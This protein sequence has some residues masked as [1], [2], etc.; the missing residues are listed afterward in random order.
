MSGS[1]EDHSKALAEEMMEDKEK[2]RL[3][4]YTKPSIIN[5][6]GYKIKSLQKELEEV[7]VENEKWKKL[8]NEVIYDLEHEPNRNYFYDKANELLKGG[9]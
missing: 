3:M 6:L 8:A 5:E 9:E 4:M 2:A 1:V 7:K